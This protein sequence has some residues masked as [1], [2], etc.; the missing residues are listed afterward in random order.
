MSSIKTISFSG[1]A[2]EKMKK[3]SEVSSAV[4]D[5]LRSH[6]D[7]I[8]AE[9][10][11]NVTMRKM[12]AISGNIH[13][14]SSIG[15]YWWPNPDTP[16]GLPYVRRDGILTP[17]A[18]DPVTHEKL[19]KDIFN[20]SLAA[21]YFDEKRYAN[22]AVEAIYDWFLNP[23]TYMTP[24]AEYAQSIPGICDGRGIG[25][26]DFRFSYYIFDAVFILESLGYIDSNTVNKLKDW[27]SKF[28]D[29]LL[30]SENGIT[31]DTEPNNHGT[32]YDALVISIAVF[33]GREALFKKI[34]DTAY[35]RR[36]SD[37]IEPDGSQP[38]ELARTQGMLYT[39]ANLE[40]LIAIADIAEI[41]GCSEFFKYDE[42]YGACALK[43]AIDFI[44]PYA[45]SPETF[46]YQEINPSAIPERMAYSLVW[47]D[48]RCPSENYGEKAKGFIKEPY[49]WLA[50]PFG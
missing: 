39:L 43:K 14:Y 37:Q 5:A 35:V 16:D 8:A 11:I 27:Y 46:P 19:C 33:T 17:L 31:E 28:G 50:R 45:L 20:L 44:Y 47:L 32:W 7:K 1:A 10:R 22:A 38:L 42:K 41:H 23:D 4:L 9:P 25:I 36:F 18:K 29:W 13:D 40:G 26:I 30:T 6:A 48:A 15:S 34:C 21:Y 49:L 12:R 24:H 3:N 2:L